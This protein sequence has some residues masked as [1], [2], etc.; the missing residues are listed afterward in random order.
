MTDRDASSDLAAADAPAP[1]PA[2]DALRQAGAERF[3]PLR[4][5]YLQALARRAGA[6]QGRVRTLVDGK[7]AAALSAFAERFAEAQNIARERIADIA[8]Q[9]PQA[10]EELQRLFACGD[11]KGIE[12]AAACLPRSL[13]PA[14]LS[15]LLRYIE[16][17]APEHVEAAQPGPALAPAAVAGPGVSAGRPVGPRAELKTMRYF[18]NTWSKLSVD[19]QVAQAI[20]QAPENAGPLNS[21]FLVLRAL[22]SM[23]DISPDYLNRFI[24]YVDTLLCLDH[25]D[26]KNQP[27]AKKPAKAKTAKRS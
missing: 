21:H 2:L 26:K 19:K 12:R 1:V 18:R 5:H 3:D 25:A 8:G 11:F 16:Q 6:Q 15:E 24:S 27:V 9:Q 23:R 17:H 22:E 7:L 13:S 4:F 14:P 20:E 10:A